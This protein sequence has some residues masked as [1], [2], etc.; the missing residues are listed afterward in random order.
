M[1]QGF[2]Y[3]KE[4]EGHTIH[5]FSVT[6]VLKHFLGCEWLYR[7]SFFCLSLRQ[8]DVRGVE[9]TLLEV[10]LRVIMGCWGFGK[11]T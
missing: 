7:R 10:R 5:H 3:Q 2:F 1:I 9:L 4:R 6:T 8:D 11:L